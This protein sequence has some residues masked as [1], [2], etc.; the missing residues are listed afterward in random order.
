MKTEPT[1]TSFAG[2]DF[3]PRLLAGLRRRYGV[4]STTFMWWP[5]TWFEECSYL[6]AEGVVNRDGSLGL[7]DH[8]GFAMAFRMSDRFRHRAKW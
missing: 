7:A 4:T 6:I 2:T 1:S 3:S 5:I 8:G